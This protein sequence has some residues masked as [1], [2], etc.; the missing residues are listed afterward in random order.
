MKF[1]FQ[2]PVS[3]L[4]MMICCLIFPF[5]PSLHLPL[6]GGMTVTAVES[7]QALMLFGFAVFSFFYIRPFELSKGQ[8]QFW[9]W[10]V[11][12]WIML[13]GRSTSWGR[14]YFPEVPKIYFRG[15]SVLVIAPVVF[16][17]FLAPLRQEIAYKFKH[18]S[19]PI[20]ALIL[21][22][23][24][25]LMSDGIEHNRFF[26]HFIFTDFIYKDL[27][28][29]LYEFPLIIGLFLVAY[30]LMKQDCTVTKSTSQVIAEDDLSDIDSKLHI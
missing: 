12:W 1:D 29:E 17:L 28:E 9:L 14:D 18:V 25:L 20:W 8:K 21:A 10:S 2:L 19:L 11:A 4:V 24:G 27:M 6:L 16:M 7:I 5:L 13:F 15:I 26:I 22:F 3:I 23:I 30:P